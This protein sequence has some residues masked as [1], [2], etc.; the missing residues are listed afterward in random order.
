MA[1]LPLKV[2]NN[3][4]T[5]MSFV[6]KPN[7]KI[8]CSDYSISHFKNE[9]ITQYECSISQEGV[10]SST[11]IFEILNYDVFDSHDQLEFMNIISIA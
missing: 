1:C 7:S 10:S 9:I 5:C 8:F 4:K 6:R 11:A 3:L 2:C